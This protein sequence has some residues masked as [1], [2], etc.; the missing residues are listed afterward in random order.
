MSEEEWLMERWDAEHE[1]GTLPE[2]I[3]SCERC[4]GDVDE[5]DAEVI[6]GDIYD[7]QCAA[8]ILHT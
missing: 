7:S 1:G 2:I 5:D 6:D 8:L 4:G 3:G